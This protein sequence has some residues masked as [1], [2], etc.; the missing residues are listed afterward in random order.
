MSRPNTSRFYHHHQRSKHLHGFT[1]PEVQT[2][3]H[4]FF[5]S[6][7]RPYI[8]QVFFSTSRSIH[9]LH[10]F[11]ISRLKHLLHIIPPAVQTPPRLFYHQHRVSDIMAALRR[12]VRCPRGSGQRGVLKKSHTQVVETPPPVRN[13]GIKK[14]IPVEIL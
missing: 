5:P 1:S 11:T 6:S 14:Q 2:S 12:S 10:G 3:L 4:V 13:E 8:S 9:L 7:S